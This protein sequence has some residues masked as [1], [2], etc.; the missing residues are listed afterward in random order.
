MQLKIKY[1][2]TYRQTTI[3]KFVYVFLELY[4]TNC[5]LWVCTVAVLKT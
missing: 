1:V 3:N 4:L 2:A 5:L